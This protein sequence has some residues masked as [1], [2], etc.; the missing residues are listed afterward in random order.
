V[1]GTRPLAVLICAIGGQGGGVL[2]EWIAEAAHAARL[3]ASATS[4]PGVAQRTGATTYYLELC[5]ERDDGCEPLFCLFP[6]AGN[7]DLVVSLEPL[8]ALRALRNGYAGRETTVVTATARVYAIGEKTA[9]ADA[10]TPATVALD[11]I[12]AA[13]KQLIALDGPANE[14]GAVNA[15]LFG[16]VAATGVLPLSAEHCR[17]AIADVGIAPD[18]NLA[19]FERGFRGEAC[20]PG[21]GARALEP[22]PPAFREDLAEFPERH[23]TLIAHALARLVDYQDEAYARRYLRRL[24]D[25]AHLDEQRGA[26]AQAELTGIVARRLAAWMMFEDAI[27]VAQIK[28]RR[29]RLAR[30]RGELGARAG[31]PLD[32]VDYLTPSWEDARALFPPAFAKAA[33]P[34]QGPPAARSGRALKLRTSGPWGYAALKALAAL[35]PLRPNSERFAREQRAIDAWLGTILATAPADYA[36]AC[37]LAELAALAR[38]YGE[39]G[40]RGAARLSGLLSTWTDRLRV[41]GAALAGEVA[42]LLEASRRDPD[43][44]LDSALQRS[45]R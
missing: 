4:I 17:R 36:L 18:A 32:V 44:A 2:A 12:R 7:V 13:T 9:A 37:R 1:N 41:D 26:G 34:P 39:A 45:A 42:T 8:E 11:A 40:A 21:A 43:T 14:S 6:S 5:A 25:V 29:G 35:R 28:T 16:A 15:R 24:H 30:I 27:R 38:G 23:R 31:E 22:L 10:V 20:D 19:E 33:P 3:R